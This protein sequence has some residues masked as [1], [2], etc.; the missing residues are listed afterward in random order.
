MEDDRRPDRRY[1]EIRLYLPG[2]RDQVEHERYRPVQAGKQGD[3]V[4]QGAILFDV[5]N[6]TKVWALFDA[7]EMDLPFLS[8][9]DPVEFT[10][11]AL[12]GKKF[13]GKI[14][15]IDP[16]LNTTTRTAKVRVEVP[17]ASLE[18]KPEMYATA[19]VSAPLRNY[20][21]EIV[22]PQTAVLWTGKRAIVYVK[23]P[24]TNTPAFLMREV[25][26]GPSLGNSYVILNGLREGEEIV[27]NGVFAIDASAQLEG[28]T[29]MMNNGDEP[30]SL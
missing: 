2:C 17:N 5:A 14:S 13:S 29:S 11:Q 22:V 15:F 7:F 28:K 23:Q 18:L 20:K 12:P 16:I 9:G 24:D 21:N 25:E 19:N 26:L 4:S 10:L 8:K 30:P 27:T 6:L 1:R 3:Y